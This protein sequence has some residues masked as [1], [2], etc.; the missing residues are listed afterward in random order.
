MSFKVVIPARYDSTRLPG[1]P[2]RDIAG[3]S[4]IQ[5]VWQRASE[6]LAND[7]F[8]A[9]DSAE[10]QTHCESFGAKVVMTAEHHQSGTDRVYEVCDKEG[11][12]D[13]TIVINLQ[14][15]EPM[16]PPSLIDRLYKNIASDKN[17]GIA[18]L[19]QPILDWHHFLDPNVVKVVRDKNSYARYFSRA[20]IPWDRDIASALQ[21]SNQVKSP[22]VEYKIPVGDSASLPQSAYR[23]FGVYAY[24]VKTL[25]AFVEWEQAVSEKIE[26]LEQLRALE[27]GVS[28]HCAVADVNIPDGVDTE[29]DLIR[30]Q[31]AFTLQD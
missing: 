20:P 2:L 1:K 17:I 18:T 28:I 22:T 10:I 27:N 25:R 7:V 12:E 23:H 24:R 15:D 8:V 19:C 21:T 29:A 13:D 9:T 5:R 26:S 11:W 14:G 31:K 4:M 3:Q 30:V 16:F 6:S